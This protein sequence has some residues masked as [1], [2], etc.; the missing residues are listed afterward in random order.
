MSF[1]SGILQQQLE[2]FRRERIAQIEAGVRFARFEFRHEVPKTVLH[3]VPSGSASGIEEALDSNSD[4]SGRTV[5]IMNPA[6]D[7]FRDLY[8]AGYFAHDQI[9]DTGTVTAYTRVEDNGSIE[10]VETFLVNPE[11][12]SI[13][14]SIF[15][16]WLIAALRRYLELLSAV[17]VSVPVYVMLSLL[18]V[19]GDAT[20][21]GANDADIQ[22]LIHGSN[23]ELPPIT[24]L[25]FEDNP[26]EFMQPA[27]TAVWKFF[28][29]SD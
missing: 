21:A 9:E 22:P 12:G 20:L 8:H 23:L 11:H 28:Q 2:D 27:F 24:V 13:R 19:V 4:L 29:L 10:A 14:A 25:G 5:P 26:A 1:D 17:G 7:H 16:P 18:G 15:K 6:H 3:I